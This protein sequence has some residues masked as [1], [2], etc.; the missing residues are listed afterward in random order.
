MTIR[1]L[2]LFKPAALSTIL[3]FGQADSATA[4][5]L[6]GD[7]PGGWTYIYHAG[8]GQAQ[9]GP[10]DGTQGFTA[11]DGTWSHENGSDEWDGSPNGSGA[12]GG[13]TGNLV[14]GA[15][16]Y[17]RI[18]DPG[19]PTDHAMPDP[20]NRKIMFGHDITAEGATDT[21]LNDGVTISF[22]VR[23]ATGGILD[24]IH[25]DTAGT[26][27]MSGG[28][29]A[30]FPVGGNGYTVHDGGKGNFNIQQNSGGTIGFT[31]ALA[32]DAANSPTGNLDISPATAALLMNNLNG[33]TNSG[34]VD[35]GEAGTANFV[36]I[37]GATQWHEFYITIQAGGA[38]THQVSVYVDGLSTPEV[39][40]VT[41]G[42]GS[43]Y[44]GISDITFGMGATPQIGA[45]DVD[46]FAWAPG[47]A[48]PIGASQPGDVDGD[49]DVDLADF[50]FIRDRFQQSAPPG[51]QGDLT[52]DGFVDFRDFRQWKNNFPFPADPAGAAIPEPSGMIVALAAVVAAS[53]MRRRQ[54]HLSF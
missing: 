11:L 38:G 48:P 39:F 49:G 29:I 28:A 50:A 40:D 6:F 7:P 32:S 22:R 34:T 17:I 41:A 14:D 45:M 13:V 8:A 15:T 27:E 4:G 18:Q 19:D 25:P 21:I 26:G 3:L 52:R 51:E 37:A 47:V 24:N 33:T 44:G 53:A 5:V 36:S 46:F 31:L 20:S 42:S 23:L 35:T 16:T 54:P 1:R 12:P 2:L 30:P 9:P 43:D 10:P